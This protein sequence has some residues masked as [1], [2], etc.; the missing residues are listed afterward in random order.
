MHKFRII[1]LS[2]F[3]L[4]AFP[5]P[6]LPFN[7]YSNTYDDCNTS[8]LITPLEYRSCRASVITKYLAF[9][10]STEVKFLLRC[11]LIIREEKKFFRNERNVFVFV[12]YFY[13]AKTS[14]KNITHVRDQNGKFK[15]QFLPNKKSPVTMYFTCVRCLRKNFIRAHVTRHY[16][17]K[18]F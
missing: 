6:T 3:Q 7:T 12:C 2:Y 11:R 1:L 9:M 8:Y 10:Q 5:Q 18:T 13:F 17:M 14:D 15:W 16:Q 4:R